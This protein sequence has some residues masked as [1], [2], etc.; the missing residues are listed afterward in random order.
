MKSQ[1]K[2]CT[3]CNPAPGFSS[4]ILLRH[5]YKTSVDFYQDQDVSELVPRAQ[6][7]AP[8]YLIA[9][10]DDLIGRLVSGRPDL[11]RLRSFYEGKRSPQSFAH[12]TKNYGI[13]NPGRV[14]FIPIISPRIEYLKGK[15]LESGIPH[16]IA[17]SNSYALG[18]RQQEQNTMF[19]QEL[20][21]RVMAGMQQQQPAGAEGQE[22][23][24]AAPAASVT[25]DE[26]KRL[27]E[28]GRKFQSS[29]EISSQKVLT[30]FLTNP[31]LRTVLLMQ[32]HLENLLVERETAFDTRPGEPGML[33]RHQVVPAHQLYCDAPRSDRYS[34]TATCF[35]RRELLSVQYVLSRWGGKMSP[36][37]RRT[38]AGNHNIGG[39]W[40]NL[41][42]GGEKYL[43][44]YR[45]TDGSET[46]LPTE[47]Y[48]QWVAQQDGH[49]GNMVEVFTIQWIANNEIDLADIAELPAAVAEMGLTAEQL[50]EGAGHHLENK[51]PAGK[52]SKKKKTRWMQH[53]YEVVRIGSNIY[54]EMGE[55]RN[56][57]RPTNEPWRV[58]PTFR[59]YTL[60]VSL[61]EKATD[62]QDKSDIFNYLMENAAV[63]A[64]TKGSTVP[65]SD[66]P[67]ELG[68]TIHERITSSIGYRRLGQ[69]LINPMQQGGTKGQFSNYQTFD[70]T[71]DGSTLQGYTTVINIYDEQASTITGVNR[72]MLGSIEERDG[73]DVT[74]QAIQGGTTVTRPVFVLFDT[75]MGDA[76]TDALNYSRQS[77]KLGTS[78]TNKQLLLGDAARGTFLLD[79]EQFSLG[80]YRVSV[81]DGRKQKEQLDRMIQMAN[82]F[83]VNNVLPPEEAINVLFIDSA[84][85]AKEHLVQTLRDAN[86]AKM[87]QLTEENEQ[88]KKQLQQSQGAQ[89]KAAQG[90]AAAVQ[91]QAKNDADRVQIEA[92]AQAADER[93]GDE[94]NDLRAQE[95]AL[96]RD[97]AVT[98]A[99][100]SSEKVADLK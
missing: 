66:I 9:M 12:L 46:V 16:Q 99:S 84:T 72:Q 95:V 57:V 55:V 49:H 88:L 23:Q 92:R 19:I 45:T 17:C 5:V 83:A 15:Y 56:P 40:E 14:P 11:R 58:L 24:G 30:E 37:E 100:K 75:L 18:V 44:F 21:R 77:L 25:Q 76:F 36:E 38:I 61:V 63:M 52:T 93:Q 73:K 51:A 48:R 54:P 26:L 70:D 85:E 59:R 87:Q 90:D 67:L 20:T 33:A 94:E 69:H 4:S 91:Q 86:T 35:V 50:M 1:V 60:P 32:D 42:L 62:T 89:E 41:P 8:P 78:G 34:E 13:G 39:P 47:Q 6:K 71:L 43:D 81:G 53:L 28:Q 29:L 74:R 96:Q 7:A 82:D 65:T 31:E 22:G 80:H 3:F 27:H 97:Q 79:A 98:N 2:R 10:A 64:G 68:N